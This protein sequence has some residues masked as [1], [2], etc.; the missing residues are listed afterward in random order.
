MEWMEGFMQGVTDYY[1]VLEISPTAAQ[2]DISAAY[3]R[4]VK[5]YHPDVSRDPR[6]ESYMK[7]I[8]QAYYVLRDDLRRA[9]YDRTYNPV[10]D[11]QPVRTAW[12]NT[13]EVAAQVMDDYFK[14][15]QA[16]DYEAAYQMLCPY[17]QLYVTQASFIKWRRSVQRLFTIREY[18]AHAG[19][20]HPSYMLEA[21]KSAPACR[22][23]VSVLEKNHATQTIDRYQISKFVVWEDG[24]W[25]VF[26][27]YRDLNEIARVFE[28][29]S[30]KHRQSE[31]TRHW[32]A[33][34]NE[35]CRE[36]DMLSLSGLVKH[37]KRELY[38]SERYGQAI[39]M[40]CIRI[41][42]PY[43]TEEAMADLL[44]TAAQALSSGLRE[45]D[46]IAYLGGGMFALLLIELKKRHASTIVAR[47]MRRLQGEVTK[48][49]GISIRAR[50]GFAPY[51]GEPLEKAFETLSNNLT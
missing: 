6:A 37:A 8:N 3:R 30:D 38:R 44:E 47:L 15:L 32:E 49:H 40:V 36:L 9:S 22:V 33:Y 21:G 1:R 10:A 17:D 20:L 27:G 25:R 5:I 7:D 48:I 16:G 28:D 29:L 23:Y 2:A 4:L 11:A 13:Q 19:E 39:T 31:M 34:C 50:H 51:R 35:Y 26:L 12:E 24:H 41:E 18:K 45:T 46:L 14:A 43:N 42:S